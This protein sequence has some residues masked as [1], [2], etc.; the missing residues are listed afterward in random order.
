M[1]LELLFRYVCPMRRN[2]VTVMMMVV[3]EGGGVFSAME[4]FHRKSFDTCFQ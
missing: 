3:L 4:K 1:N 2:L